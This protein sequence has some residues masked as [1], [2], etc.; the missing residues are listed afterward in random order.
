MISLHDVLRQMEDTCRF[1]GRN[2]APQRNETP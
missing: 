2:L 1:I